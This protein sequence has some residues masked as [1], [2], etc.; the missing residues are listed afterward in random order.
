MRYLA[1][2]GLLGL[3]WAQP[4][5]QSTPFCVAVIGDSGTGARPQYEIGARLLEA[6]KKSRFHSVLMLGDNLY[7]SQRPKDFHTKFELPYAGL[8][9]S[10]VEFYAS[11]GNHDEPSQKSYEPFHMGG[12]NYYSARLNDN[13]RIFALDS[14]RVDRSQ[15]EWF[16]RELAAA[17][18]EWKIVFFHH[19]I[20][21]SGARHGS[22]LQ[23]RAALEPL[24]VKYGVDVVLAGHDHIYERIKPQRGVNYFVVG[25]SAK[26]RAGNALSMAHTAKAYDRDLSFLLLEIDGDAMHFQAISRKGAVVDSGSIHKLRAAIS[27]DPAG[28]PN[29]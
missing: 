13:V 24:F 8:L 4:A 16:Q 25:A 21:S 12:R 2:L 26:L 18:E 19:P 28:V 7:G 23:L 22:D 9:A 6:Q 20:Y 17:R 29:H 15:L 27:A 3:A 11:L 1:I 5:A 14:N 10:G